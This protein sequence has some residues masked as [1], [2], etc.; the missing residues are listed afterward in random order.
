[1]TGTFSTV[2]PND[3]TRDHLTTRGVA[4]LIHKSWKHT[5]HRQIIKK[6]YIILDCMTEGKRFTQAN[7]HLPSGVE[8]RDLFKEILDNFATAGNPSVVL[9]GDFN[10]IINRLDSSVNTP[11]SADIPMLKEKLAAWGILDI[12]R[13]LHPT[14]RR[15]SVVT[16]WK[17][18]DAHTIVMNRIDY[19]SLM[20]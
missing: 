10:T 2:N 19:L 5:I 12:W 4:I 3:D 6:D 17:K 18:R 20:T 16:A 1:M 14:S 8:K 7:V 9:G 11:R 13:E 15:Y